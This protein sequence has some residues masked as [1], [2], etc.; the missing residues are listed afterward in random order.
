V[1][2]GAVLTGGAEVEASADVDWPSSQ[3]RQI[4]APVSSRTIAAAAAMSISHRRREARPVVAA[5]GSL[6]GGEYRVAAAGLRGTG[7]G[8][9]GAAGRADGLALARSARARAKSEQRG[10]RSSGVLGQRGCQ[11]GVEG[12]ELGADVGQ[13]RRRGVE[14]SADDDCRV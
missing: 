10:K 3:G 1:L 9:V 2:V 7:A 12:G 4:R 8:L 13:W 5:S 14:V 11:Y 6:A